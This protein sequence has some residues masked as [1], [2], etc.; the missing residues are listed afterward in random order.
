MLDG[1]ILFFDLGGTLVRVDG[2]FT[3]G[4]KAVL[5]QTSHRAARTV[6]VTG[7]PF[8]DPQVKEFMSL[9]AKG[10]AANVVAYV[11]R[12]AKRFELTNGCWTCD[13]N[14]LARY[15]LEEDDRGLI[16]RAAH[17]V[18]GDLAVAPIIPIQCIDDV[19]IRINLLPAQ[20][21]EFIAHITDALRKGGLHDYKA[22]AEGRTSVFVMRKMAGKRRAV[23]YEL[24][25]KDGLPKEDEAVYFGNEF[26]VGGNDREVLDLAGL[27]VVALGQCPTHG[28]AL[29]P[30]TIGDSPEDLFAFLKNH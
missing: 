18:L 7:Q 17:W 21:I 16:T 4:A 22:V 19:A 9:F 14:Y 24:T 13:R 23:E 29:A 30:I 11:T 5:L 26:H 15:F 2:R 20:R 8:D 1:K 3:P 10:N 6:L 25:G 28:T 27:Q 12:G